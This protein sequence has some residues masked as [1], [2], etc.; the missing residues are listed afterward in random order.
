MCVQ[1]TV[2]SKCFN[3]TH[4]EGQRG[5]KRGRLLDFGTVDAGVVKRLIPLLSEC[6]CGQDFGS[7]PD[8][9]AQLKSL[10]KSHSLRFQVFMLVSGV[11]VGIVP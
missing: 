1:W 4:T 10:D 8:V 6:E 11:G 9:V 7:C 2:L 3:A 5:R